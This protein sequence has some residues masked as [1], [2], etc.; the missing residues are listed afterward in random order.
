MLLLFDIFVLGITRC[1]TFGEHRTDFDGDA[2][3]LSVVPFDTWMMVTFEEDSVDLCGDFRRVFLGSL[4]CPFLVLGDETFVSAAVADNKDDSL[5]QLSSPDSNPTAG[6]VEVLPRLRPLLL[7]LLVVLVL[8]LLLAS[9]SSSLPLL[10][11]QLLMLLST[12]TST[13]TFLLLVERFR[14]VVPGS[15]NTLVTNVVANED[16]AD[17]E[18]IPL[19][20]L[21]LFSL[22]N[23]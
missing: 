9:A 13:N 21:K 2:L 5:P 20:W 4:R 8:L 15:A 19:E 12:L 14:D 7:L 23:F 17:V 22:V 3:G 16:D 11:L 6:P 10:L 1:F 18:A